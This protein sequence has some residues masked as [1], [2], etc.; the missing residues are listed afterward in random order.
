MTAKPEETPVV[1][2]ACYEDEAYESYGCK[3]A[4]VCQRFVE[5]LERGKKYLVSVTVQE[6]GGTCPEKERCHE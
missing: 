4:V 6:V 1:F 5:G 3:G 2:H